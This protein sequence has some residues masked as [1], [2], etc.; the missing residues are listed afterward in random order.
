MTL[1]EARA[2]IGRRVIYRRDYC[3]TEVGVITSVGPRSVFVR[4]GSD[5]GSKGTEPADLTL[6]NE[7]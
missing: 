7:V 2:C 4:Y 1:D 6:E 5:A 3:E